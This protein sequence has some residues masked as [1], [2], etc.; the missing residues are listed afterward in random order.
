MRFYWMYVYTY[1]SCSVCESQ[2]HL[3]PSLWYLID[4]DDCK[5]SPCQNGGTCVDGTNKYTCNCK[6]GFTGDNCETGKY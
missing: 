3:S 6:A 2:I 1:L 4:E 5:T